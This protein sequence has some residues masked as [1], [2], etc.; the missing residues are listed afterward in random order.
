MR[1]FI[2]D[3]HGTMDL[4]LNIRNSRMLHCPVMGRIDHFSGMAVFLVKIGVCVSARLYT[5]SELNMKYGSGPY[6]RRHCECIELNYDL[7]SNFF[8]FFVAWCERFLAKTA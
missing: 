4:K 2:K 5:L 7:N 8:L 6:F 1:L 3:C